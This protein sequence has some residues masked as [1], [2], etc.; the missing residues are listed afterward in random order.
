MNKIILP[1]DPGWSQPA[2][3]PEAKPEIP[4]LPDDL[5]EKAFQEVVGEV[6]EQVAAGSAEV[7]APVE[8]KKAEE[9]PKG[10][11]KQFRKPPRRRSFKIPVPKPIVATLLEDL[12]RSWERKCYVGGVEWVDG[13]RVRK[14]GFRKGDTITLTDLVLF[15]GVGTLY[16]FAEGARESYAVRQEQVFFT[17]PEPEKPVEVSADQVPENAIASDK[18]VIIVEKSNASVDG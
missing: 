2:G 15:P 12:P 4:K 7:P 16:G 18:P 11:N 13:K 5:I 3:I 10:L 17:V 14:P 6:Q 1:G 8:E 9:P